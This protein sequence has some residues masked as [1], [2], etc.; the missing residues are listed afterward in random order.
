MTFTCSREVE[1]CFY[2]YGVNILLYRRYI[3]ELEAL[4]LLKAIQQMNHIY[5][6]EEE[7]KVI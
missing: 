3:L 4:H 5:L 6:K 2:E 7:G 1:F